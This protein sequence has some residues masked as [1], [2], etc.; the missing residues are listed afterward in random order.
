[1]LRS[2]KYMS[3][4]LISGLL[5]SCQDDETLNLKD[6]PTNQPSFTIN[7][8]ENASSVDVIAVYQQDRS[9]KLSGE[10]KRTYTF[11]IQPSP[12]DAVVTFTP[13]CTNIPADKV[14][15]SATE[16]IIPAGSA[17]TSVTVGLKEDDFSFAAATLPETIYELGV[18]AN[19]AGYNMA[20]TSY[21]AKVVIKKEA[22]T[23]L[24]SVDGKNQNS[25]TFE[26]MVEGNKILNSAPLSYSFKVK[27]DKASDYDVKVNLAYEGIPEAYLKDIQVTPSEIVIPAGKLE[28]DEITWTMKDEFVLSTEDAAVFDFQLKPTFESEEKNLQVSE[29]K[30]TVKVRTVKSVKNIVFVQGEAGFPEFSVLDR[31]GWEV[32]D[33]KNFSWGANGSAILD[34]NDGS[35]LNHNYN[36]IL[37]EFVVDMKEEHELKGIE[38]K[39]RKYFR[40]I[41]ATRYI[42]ISTSSDREAWV[43]HGEISGLPCQ[44]YHYVQFVKPVKARYV[45]V[46]IKGYHDGGSSMLSSIKMFE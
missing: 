13:I 5:F 36:D 42:T 14:E 29:E 12:E 15:L 37:G 1:M 19:V 16:V 25:A 38:F 6:F 28:S 26:R 39:Y 46:G 20:Q 7:G 27:F 35:S 10:I 44:Q 21:E 23:I 2:K 8:S 31:K 17:E 34:D 24:A 9:L 40:Y 30:G 22:F 32:N 11:A 18:V 41:Y 4:L 33:L 43:N 3:L 45:K